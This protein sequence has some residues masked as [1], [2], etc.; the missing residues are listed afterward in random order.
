MNIQEKTVQR[1]LEAYYSQL[2]Y[3][4]KREVKT[5]VGYIDFLLFKD[6][7]IEGGEKI[8]IEVK[9]WKGIKHAIGQVLSYLKYH[10]DVTSSKV[11]YFSRDGKWRGIDSSYLSEEM[12]FECVHS[13]IDIEEIY[14]CQREQAEKGNLRQQRKP[15]AS[16]KRGTSAMIYSDLKV[17]Q[18]KK[19]SSEI[20]ET[21]VYIGEDLL[22]L[23]GVEE[24]NL[25]W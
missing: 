1:V 10:K 9:E 5:P 25:R 12:S 24:L 19:E 16:W 22:G 14:K 18:N 17:E 2:G 13:F 11:V 8:L 20:L 7:G 15:R 3:V 23:Q 6:R 4:V 21:S